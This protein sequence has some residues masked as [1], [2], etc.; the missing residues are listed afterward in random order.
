MQAPIKGRKKDYRPQVTSVTLYPVPF[1]LPSAGSKSVKVY[2][3]LQ[4]IEDHLAHELDGEYD[5]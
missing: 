5:S 2:D 4:E 3:H 1:S